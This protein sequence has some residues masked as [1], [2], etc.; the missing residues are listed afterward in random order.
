MLEIYL[1]TANF[2]ALEKGYKTG[3]IKGIT[4]NPTILKQENRPRFESLQQLALLEPE[5]VFIQV[6]G[7]SFEERKEDFYRIYKFCEEQHINFGPKVPIDMV[8]LELISYIINNYPDIKILGTAIYSSDQ[9]IIAALAG[10]HYLAPY[11]NRMLNESIDAQNEIAKMR[12]FFDEHQ[13]ET[14]IL[15]ASFK[16]SAQVFEAIDAGAH[17]VTVGMDVY[18]S[19]VNKR[20]AKLAIEVFNQDGKE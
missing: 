20:L 14:K 5:I 15:C 7:D 2:E 16:N 18:E 17:A 1:D 13:L 8:G 3:I 9:G 6:V 10:C 11:Y 12:D 19:M 4:T